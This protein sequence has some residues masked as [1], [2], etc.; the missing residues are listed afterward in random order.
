MTKELIDK[1][2]EKLESIGFD[3]KQINQ[4]ALGL[5]DNFTSM[6]KL[7]P[8]LSV[9]EIKLYKECAQK[10]K[11][12]DE[13]RKELLVSYFNKGLCKNLEINDFPNF[14]EIDFV[15]EIKLFFEYLEKLDIKT[16]KKIYKELQFNTRL[17]FKDLLIEGSNYKNFDFNI[18]NHSFA[19]KLLMIPE[20][21]KIEKNFDILKEL[22]I[23]NSTKCVLIII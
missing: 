18:L 6:T 15:K 1:E 3:F 11:S 5:K 8:T 23:A 14:K 10:Y 7:S 17:K 13:E 9:K 2:L 21:E 16:I 12:V 20:K 19:S 22:E 4:I